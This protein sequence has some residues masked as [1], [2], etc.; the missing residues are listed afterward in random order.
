MDRSALTVAPLLLALVLVSAGIGKLRG[1]RRGAAGLTS[2]GVPAPFAVP[3]VAAAHP[4]VE[5]ALAVLLTLGT[6]VLGIL[7]AAASLALMATYLLLV[8]NVLRRGEDVDCDCFGA[9]GQ[10][11]VTR[12]TVGRNAWYVVLAGLSLWAHLD[13]S[14]PL[15]AMPRMGAGGWGWLAAVL[16]SGVTV[17]L[18]VGPTERTPGRA[19]GVDDDAELE[20]YLR[21]P[22]PAVPVTLSDGSVRSLRA[23]SATRPQLLLFVSTT[24]GLC[25]RIIERAPEWR[26]ALPMLDVRLV[27]VMPRPGDDQTVDENA[28]ELTV[29]DPERWAHDTLGLQG[30]PSAVALGVDGLLAG[31]PVAGPDDVETFVA[32]LTAELSQLDLTADPQR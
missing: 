29:Y 3:A 5:I 32:D 14:G 25:H 23:L 1:P 16:A 11:Q 9:F 12:S 10:S 22:T 4:W 27:Y 24:C 6:G 7:G 2:L 15:H 30:T 26:E 18:T 19:A 13:D 31:G 8:V 17:L 20:D 28:D 21:T